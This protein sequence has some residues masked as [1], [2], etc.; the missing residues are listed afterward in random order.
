MKLNIAWIVEQLSPTLPYRLVL[1]SA[2]VIA[3]LTAAT[4]CL[5]EKRLGYSAEH[6]LEVQMDARYLALAEIEPRTGKVLDRINFGYLHASAG[7]LTAS[8][9]MLGG[10]RARPFYGHPDWA[11]ILSGFMDFIQ[12]DGEPGHA[13]LNPVFVE[14]LPFITPV[15]VFLRDISGDALH[16]GVSLS[17]A[18]HTSENWAW[19]SGLALEY[20][21]I[22]KF[23]ILFDTL[24]LASNF[25]GE[26]DYAGTYHS[27]TPFLGIQYNIPSS[28]A[29]YKFS[30]RLNLAW[31]LPHRGFH[32]RITGPG[33][34]LEGDTESAGNRKHIPDPFAG[35][36]FTLESRQHGWR[37]D[38]GASL[39]LGLLEG[40]V[41]KGNDPPLFAH[42]SWPL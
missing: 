2:F 39:W 14:T 16:A 22:N 4:V 37:F 13:V 12:L 20:Y 7:R 29:P 40:K 15:N 23:S 35:M 32:G 36:G 9:L 1:S 27:V 30:T 31:P 28:S 5:A 42:I 19:Q 18:H 33:F 25:S 10:Q 41:H 3:F 17:V 26:V 8:A 24:N 6:M 38:I 21:K 34:S 11:L